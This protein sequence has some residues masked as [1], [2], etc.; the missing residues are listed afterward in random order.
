[1]RVELAE[2]GVHQ[3]ASEE[4]EQSAKKNNAKELIGEE[5]EEEEGVLRGLGSLLGDG[6]LVTVKSSHRTLY[7]IREEDKTEAEFQKEK[8]ETSF[9][10]DRNRKN[11][12]PE[13]GDPWPGLR[14]LEAK[15][16]TKKK[17]QWRA[18]GGREI[19]RGR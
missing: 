12:L 7:G 3:N 19:E 18:I 8:T 16:M 14:N 9:H 15:A 2:T 5:E 4:N 1:M 10:L 6:R 11:H 13:F 17:K